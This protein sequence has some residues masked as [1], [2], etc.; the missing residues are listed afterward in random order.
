MLEHALPVLAGL[1]LPGT[2]FAAVGPVGAP[3]HLDWSDLSVLAE[4]GWEI[5][6]HTVTHARLV[7]LDDAG[8]DQELRDSREAIEER[9]GRP[10][11][12]IAYPYGDTDARVRAAAARA[13]FTAGCTSEGTL[14]GDPLDWPRVGVNGDD[15]LLAFRLKTSLLGRALRGSALDAP[16]ERARRSLQVTVIVCGRRTSP[17]RRSGRGER[18]RLGRGRRCGG[19]RSRSRLRRGSLQ[20]R[21]AGRARPGRSRCRRAGAPV[22]VGERPRLVAD[23]VED[24]EREH[25]VERRVREVQFVDVHLEV[26]VWVVEVDRHPR[27]P[28]RLTS[29]SSGRSGETWSRRSGGASGSGRVRSWS[30]S[31]RCRSYEPQRGQYRLG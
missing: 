12:S 9:L 20:A 14:R 6:S 24:G 1:G 27:D 30:A 22:Q 23:G 5:G 17:R 15:G 4:A 25:G 13:G 31:R 2:V 28:G 11:R 16:L 26:D 18:S 19:S 7:E 3:G 10:C 21:A 29:R 8:L